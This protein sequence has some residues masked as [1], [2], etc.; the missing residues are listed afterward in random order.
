M[1]RGRVLALVTVAAVLLP[2]AAPVHAAV[3]AALH[4]SVEGSPFEPGA[5][6]P[7]DRIAIAIG[8]DEPA[9]LSV[10]IRS[11]EGRPVRT[12][13]AAEP[14]DPGTVHLA[15]EGRD[16]RG[17]DLPDGPYRLRVIATFAD[18]TVTLDRLIARAPVAPYDAAPG[19]ILVVLNPG[20]GGP[21]PGAVYDGK[22]ESDANLEI[23]LKL[24]DMLV[25]SGIR[26]RMTRA[27]DV[28]IAVP[29]RDVSGDGVADHADELI[30]RNDIVNLA[31]A[32][33]EITTMNNAAGC[34]CA[35]GTESYTNA[36][37][38]WSPEGTDLARYIQAAHLRYLRPFAS[39]AW[40][41]IDRGVR[42]YD[43]SSVR[44]YHPVEMPR[45]VMAPSVLIESLYMDH[46]NE[47]HV[48]SRAEVRTA[49]AAA[50]FDG[51]ARFLSTRRLA[52]GY[53]LLDVPSEARAGGTFDAAL[54]LE[55]HGTA[56]SKG[57]VLEARAVPRVPGPYYARP[58]RGRLLASIPVP[59]GLA[60]GASADLA[61]EGVPV[62][63]ARGDW[64]ILLDVRPPGG[65]TLGD[66]GSI[67]AQWDLRVGGAAPGTLAIAGVPG[68][69]GLIRPRTAG[70]AFAAW[71]ATL[72]ADPLVG[73]PGSAARTAWPADAPFRR[74]AVRDLDLPP[75]SMRGM[76]GVYGAGH[77]H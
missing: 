43:F 35:R 42:F 22:R 73:T 28:A 52:A 51:I 3:D 74:F 50:F 69:G 75:G 46:P 23:A 49:L 71:V 4:L 53:E 29:L 66:R 63:P 6:A 47:L 57:W 25:A 65:R 32:D 34:H 33:L 20:H 5:A 67:R 30:A 19:A 54:R 15:W 41:P 48:L 37:R 45:P 58:A 10:V 77:P 31:R 70:A 1:L 68:P 14:H 44:P 62:P 59:D 2:S 21:D 18:R 8:L 38:S 9:G 11:W 61:L 27:K 55:N 64:T 17:R 36:H 39:P 13:A 56:A 26:V 7:H 76:A 72:P 40:T 60:P 12:L 24:R 16:D